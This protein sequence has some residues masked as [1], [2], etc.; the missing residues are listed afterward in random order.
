MNHCRATVSVA[1]SALLGAC[2][3]AAANDTPWKIHTIDPS[4]EHRRGADGIRLADANGDG[5]VDTVTGW[6]QGNAIRVCLNPGPAKAKENWPAVT[7]GAVSSAEDAVFADLDGD[8]ALDVVSSCEGKTMQM[9]AHWAP[10]DSSRYLDADA[11]QTETFP[12]AK[13]ESRWMFALPM[14]ADGRHGVDLV[15]GS[16]S[17]NGMIGLLIAPENPRDLVAWKLVKLYSAGWIMNTFARDMD[18]D[19]DKDIVTVDRKGA[20]SGILW[21]ENPGAKRADDAEAWVEHRIGPIGYEPLFMDIADLDSDGRPDV[22]TSSRNGVI[23]FMRRGRGKNAWTTQDIPNP[24]GV[25]SGKSVRVADIDLDGR[26]DLVHTTNTNVRKEDK[27]KVAVAWMSYQ[28]SADS[29]R[30]TSHA[31]SPPGGAKYDLIQLVDLDAD[32]DLDLMCCE[33]NAQLGVFW[34]ENPTR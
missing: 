25:H 1:I 34:Y 16:K 28:G 20:K 18:G 12:T 7:V 26:L 8:G 13:G 19:G 3:A 15:V 4:T 33:E 27:A 23:K 14:Q 32:G 6:E 30:W 5:L 10:K 9:Y 21:L 29:A 31:I 11:W 17:P 24:F 2:F 22:I